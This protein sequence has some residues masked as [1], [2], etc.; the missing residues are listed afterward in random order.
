MNGINEHVRKT[1]ASDRGIEES[2]LDSAQSSGAITAAEAIE[3]G[4]IDE[5]AYLQDYVLGRSGKL[6]AHEQYLEHIKTNP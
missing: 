1:I 5:T 3:L 6:G 2:K 4:L